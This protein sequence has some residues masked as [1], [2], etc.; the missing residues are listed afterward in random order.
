MKTPHSPKTTLG[1]AASSS[2]MNVRGID[3]RRGASSARKIAVSSP[4]GAAM[5]TAMSDV[6]IVPTTN[7]NAP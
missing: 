7:G 3:R 6:R 1:M 2:I 5:M 4:M